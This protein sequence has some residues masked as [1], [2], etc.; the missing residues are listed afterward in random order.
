MSGGPSRASDVRGDA[1]RIAAKLREAGF[2]ALFAGGCVRDRLLGLAPRE[3]DIA[4]N[5]TPEQVRGVFPRAIGVGEAFGVMLLRRG[6]ASFEIATFRADLEYRDGR[7]PEG[8]RFADARADAMRRDFTINGLFEDPRDGRV[9]DFVGGEQDL[10][11]RVLRAIG[12]PAARLSEDRLRALRG[13]RFAARFELS[14]DPA[15]ASAIESL[16]GDLG[17]VSRERL[18]QELRRMLGERHRARA[19]TLLESWGLDRCLLGDHQV[20]AHP[21]LGGLPS[22]ADAMTALAAWRLDRGGIDDALRDA[23]DLQSALGLSNLERDRLEGVFRGIDRINVWSDLSVAARRRAGMDP[24]FEASLAVL[25][26]VDPA[27]VDRIDEELRRHGERQP[28]PLVRGKELLEAG[29]APGP[30]LGR[31]LEAVYDAQLEG[32]VRTTEEALSVASR[33]RERGGS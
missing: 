16:R 7:H 4:T 24:A 1:V 11:D 29:F 3:F 8:V 14:I 18:G 6:S 26:G 9:L 17:G 27:S 15:T 31:V 25:R 12:D 28:V 23:A 19:A 20:A 32:R 13:A 21:R 30:L 5:A 33:L 22:D 10:R 2:E